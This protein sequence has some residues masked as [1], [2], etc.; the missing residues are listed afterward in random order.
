MWDVASAWR[1]CPGAVIA[2]LFA[3]CHTSFLSIEMMVG[4]CLGGRQL[5]AIGWMIV[6]VFVVAAWLIRLAFDQ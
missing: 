1:F 6:A 2:I 5:W 4:R 3:F